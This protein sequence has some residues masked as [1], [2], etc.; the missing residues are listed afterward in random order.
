M[1][2][3][4]I[5]LVHM[6]RLLG[7]Q[8]TRNITVTLADVGTTLTITAPSSVDPGQIFLVAGSLTRNDTGLPLNQQI[9]K[10][11]FNGTS[12]G[13][14]ITDANGLWLRNVSIPSS[15]SFTLRAV[16]DSVVIGGLSF[17]GS[18]ISLPIRTAGLAIS[19]GLLLLGVIGAYLLTRKG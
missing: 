12:L 10:I 17:S 2:L 19:P 8:A 3:Y 15:G 6:V 5:R 9:V 18:S 1:V 11:S 4:K 14:A 13:T 7:S 16:F